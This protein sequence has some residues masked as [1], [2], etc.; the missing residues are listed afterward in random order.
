MNVEVARTFDVEI[1]ACDT[2]PHD[3]TNIRTAAV[4]TDA[5][6]VDPREQFRD[7]RDI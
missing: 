2:F 7:L 1:S 6:R 3:G 5:I 4:V